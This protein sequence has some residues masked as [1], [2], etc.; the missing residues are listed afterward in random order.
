[1][2][3]SIS[4]VDLGLFILIILLP[5]KTPFIACL[6][7]LSN[8]ETIPSKKR[9]LKMEKNKLYFTL[10]IS[11]FIFINYIPILPALTPFSLVLSST[12]YNDMGQVFYQVF[13]RRFIIMIFMSLM[14]SFLISNSI[15][16]RLASFFLVSHRRSTYFNDICIING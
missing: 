14:V 8:N 2:I 16:Q 11:I 15:L 9:P 7:V 12:Y 6:T 5:Y 3:F 4:D 13:Y 10:L 1:M